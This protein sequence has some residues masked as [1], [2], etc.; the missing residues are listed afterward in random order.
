VADVSSKPRR[1]MS[2]PQSQR[3]SREPRTHVPP[4]LSGA[5][6]AQGGLVLILAAVAGVT[7]GWLMSGGLLALT[8][9]IGG[10]Q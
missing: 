3:W 7:L 2:R 5:R 10:A 8:R 4:S 9:G 1:P 6:A